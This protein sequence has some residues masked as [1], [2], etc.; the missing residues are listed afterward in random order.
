MCTICK[1]ENIKVEED[2][3][4]DCY[5]SSVNDDCIR[6]FWSYWEY[7]TPSILFPSD[8]DKRTCFPVPCMPGP[9][10]RGYYAG[11]ENAGSKRM[12]ADGNIWIVIQTETRK[13]WTR[14][15]PESPNN[16]P[17]P[18]FQEFKDENNLEKPGLS[19]GVKNM[20]KIDE[21][22]SQIK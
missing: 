21:Q 10:G 16:S 4:E 3:C 13:R 19:E 7:S 1:D 18:L 6:G 2:L 8:S 12:G 14:Y 20:F 9:T 11:T 5:V 22:F 17:P 15:E